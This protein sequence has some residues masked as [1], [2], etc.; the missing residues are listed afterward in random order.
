MLKLL[1]IILSIFVSTLSLT[2]QED[3]LRFEHLTVDEGLSQNSIFGIIKDKHGFMWFGTWEGLCRYDGYKFKIFRADESDPT[4]L[5]NNRI[6]ML[7]KDS[8][9]NIWVALN[10]TTFICRYN[11]DTENFTRYSRRQV[12]SYIV[13][14]LKRVIV[15]SRT[16]AQNKYFRWK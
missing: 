16:H 6:N 15:R 1:K 9:E 14:S 2:A 13:D 5:A 3:V 12:K 4:A 11:Y 7:F 10:D 8:S